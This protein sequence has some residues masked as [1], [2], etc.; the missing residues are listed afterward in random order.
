MEVKIP[1]RSSPIRDWSKSSTVGCYFGIV[2]DSGSISY[3]CNCTFFIS[4]FWAR[5]DD[6]KFTWWGFCLA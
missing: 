2:Q 6:M 5:S 1:T 3:T 4:D